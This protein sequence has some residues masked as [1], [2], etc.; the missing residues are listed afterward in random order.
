MSY[1]IVRNFTIFIFRLYRII[2]FNEIVHFRDLPK[3][4]AMLLPIMVHH[5]YVC[6]KDNEELHRHITFRDCLR[7][8]KE[9]R[10]SYNK[11]RDGFEI[12]RRYR[13]VY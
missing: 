11:E 2:V 7:Q 13:F 4:V 12:S 8:H 6:D 1:S 10:D 5:L 3:I 9:G